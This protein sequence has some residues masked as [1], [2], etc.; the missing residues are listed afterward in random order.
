VTCSGFS[1]GSR[2]RPAQLEPGVAVYLYRLPLVVTV[3]AA[4]AHDG[5]DHQALDEHEDHDRHPEHELEETELLVGVRARGVERVLGRVARAA[6]DH[7]SHDE[8]QHERQR[9]AAPAGRPLRQS[10]VA[11]VLITEPFPELCRSHL[12]RPIGC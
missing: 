3:A 8:E 4:E 2:D 1:F 9:A 5:H 6:R 7:R 12:H 11:R 10:Q